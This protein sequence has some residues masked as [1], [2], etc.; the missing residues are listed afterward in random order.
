MVGLCLKFTQKSG[1][2]PFFTDMIPLFL[3]SQYVVLNLPTP[4]EPLSTLEHHKDRE[5]EFLAKT[6]L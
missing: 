1:I 5:T 2:M 3:C 4:S 6:R